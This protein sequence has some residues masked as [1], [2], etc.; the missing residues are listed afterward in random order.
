MKSESMI[1]RR[2]LLAATTGVAALAVGAPLSASAAGRNSAKSAPRTGARPPTLRNTRGK[3]LYISD[4]GT[5]RGREWF[6]FTWR[7]DGQI[8]LR[9]YCEIDDGQVE[10]DVVQTMTPDFAPLDCFMRL[11]SRGAFL[12]T[13]WVRV[14]D[15]QAECEVF[16][17]DIGRVEQ[18]IK[19]DRPVPTLVTHPLSS[20]SLLARRY[21]HSKSDRVQY[22]EGGLSTSPLLDGA[23]GPLL[24][25]N[26]RRALEYVGPERVTVPAG[27][28]DTHHYKILMKPKADGT[29]TS[30]ELWATHPDYLFVRG[31]VSG[32]LNNKTGSGTYELVEYE[33]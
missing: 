2:S 1:S 32:Y 4:D 31:T 16:N 21:D 18:V 14:T 12:G 20:D 13:G 33:G 22:W 26:G 19:L 5:E 27:T 17:K 9:A 3:I 29:P 23:S 15:T 6:S 25:Q 30:Y 28:F 24:S 7:R 11:H 8:T 10:R